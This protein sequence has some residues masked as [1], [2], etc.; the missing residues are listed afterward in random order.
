MRKSI[1]FRISVFLALLTTA[2]LLLFCIKGNS[3]NWERT[4]FWKERNLHSDALI[5]YGNGTGFW[6]G[7][8]FDLDKDVEA[9][10][11]R[12]SMAMH[13][14]LIQR[15]TDDWKTRTEV[16]QG[17]GEIE[18]FYSTGPHGMVAKVTQVSMETL[19]ETAHFIGWDGTGWKEISSLSYR[20]VKVWGSEGPVLLAVGYPQEGFEPVYASLSLDGGHT[21]NDVS[22]SGLNVAQDSLSLNTVLFPDGMLYC[23]SPFGLHRLDLK[24]HGDG[25][26]WQRV[27]SYPPSFKPLAMARRDRALFLFGSL[28]DKGFAIWYTRA[29]GTGAD[30]VSPC[31]GTPKDFMVDKFTAVDSVLYLVG[32]VEDVKNG[33]TRGY[34]HYVLRSTSPAGTDWENMDL[35]IKGSLSAVDFGADGRVWAV[36]PGNRL[37]VYKRETSHL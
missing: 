21:W 36:A 17:Q 32:Q 7:Y 27:R 24:S 35:P 4:P 16:F 26:R 28:P 10:D 14:S 19:I 3:V 12:K 2:W 18:G 30:L 23:A 1:L 6:G 20:V 25:E 9:K 34:D 22:L 15:T 13:K 33:E 31:R 29:D 37:Q 11:F 8:I 5:L